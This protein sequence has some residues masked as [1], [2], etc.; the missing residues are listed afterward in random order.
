MQNS[1]SKLSSVTV[2]TDACLVS[3]LAES[4]QDLFLPS[5]ANA[6]TDTDILKNTKETYGVR[7]RERAGQVGMLGDPTEVVCGGPSRRCPAARQGG[8]KGTERGLE[9]NPFLLRPPS[10]TGS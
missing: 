4:N 2:F 9:K 1:F 7:G 8:N 5:Q 6:T 10:P 3:Y